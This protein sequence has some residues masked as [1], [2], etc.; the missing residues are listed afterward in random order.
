MEDDREMPPPGL[1][2]YEALDELAVKDPGVA[3]PANDPPPFQPPP[4]PLTKLPLPL[5]LGKLV[6]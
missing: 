3:A 4:F 5:L 6:P 2:E 1:C